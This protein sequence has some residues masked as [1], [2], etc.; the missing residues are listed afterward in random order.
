MEYL[1]SPHYIAGYLGVVLHIMSK[2]DKGQNILA[3]LKANVKETITSF[4]CYNILVYLWYTSGIEFFGMLKAQLSGLTIILGY[5]GNSL[6][7]NLLD[8]YQKRFSKAVDGS[9]GQ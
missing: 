9:G 8:S 7:A 2:L 3:W 6:M 1:I 4:I 5:A